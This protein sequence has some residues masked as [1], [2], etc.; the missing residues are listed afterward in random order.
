MSVINYGFANINVYAQMVL[1]LIYSWWYVYGIYHRI[2][3]IHKFI[4]QLLK[5]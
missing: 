2:N 3:W 5:K 4:M 1:N